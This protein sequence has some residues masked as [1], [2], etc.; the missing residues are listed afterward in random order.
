M[1]KISK[2]LMGSLPS[3][4]NIMKPQANVNT[5]DSKGERYRMACEA[6]GRFSNLSIMNY[7]QT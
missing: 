7:F 2:L 6:T 1:K 4:P 5:I 3:K